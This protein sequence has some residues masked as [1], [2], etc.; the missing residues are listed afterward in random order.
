MR[1]CIWPMWANGWWLRAAPNWLASHFAS[2]TA[3]K[4]KGVPHSR[5]K[6]RANMFKRALYHLFI[7]QT[8]ELR[9]VKISSIFSRLW[10]H[11][12][13]NAQLRAKLP[14]CSERRRLEHLEHLE[15]LGWRSVRLVTLVLE[16][17]LQV[18]LLHKVSHALPHA[19]KARLKYI[20]K[21]L[22][23]TVRQIH[24]PRNGCRRVE[25]FH[26]LHLISMLVCALSHFAPFS[27]L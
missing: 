22:Q 14:T 26:N 4:I 9:W 20:K 21:V 7:K 15:H 23:K 17:N 24:N 16:V 10:V 11:M 25:C 12:E 2:H 19:R 5:Q 3:V 8:Y 27:S 6:S 1:L 18:M 13:S